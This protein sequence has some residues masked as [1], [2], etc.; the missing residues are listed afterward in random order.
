M[1]KRKR[2]SP[3][4]AGPVSDVS[5]P[6]PTMRMPIAD[7]VGSASAVAALDALSRETQAAR[8][9]GRVVIDIP[10]SNIETDFLV[11]DRLSTDPVEMQTLM[12]SIAVRSQQTPIEVVALD[13]GKFGLI[14]G[15]R[16]CAALQQLRALTGDAKYDCVQALV[17][18]PTDQADSYLSMVEENEIRVGLSYYERARIVIKATAQGAFVDEKQALKILYASASRTRRSKVKSFITVYRALNPSLRYPEAIGERLGLKLAHYIQ[19]G[20]KQSR[21][22]C[23]ALED[24]NISSSEQEKVILIQALNT[25]LEPKK[26]LRKAGSAK[27]VAGA[28]QTR[29]L[30]DGVVVR[31]YESG[32]IEVEGVPADMWDG[33]VAWLDKAMK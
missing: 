10:L 29:M 20:P 4:T 25:T 9:E 32:R 12:D 17:R 6:K 7:V 30:R 27:S 24:A 28:Y 19:K 1:A 23:T 15:W 16:R 3:M 26:T 5:T 8:A 2:L 33:L 21:V 22:L 11:R 13:Y 14:S 18:Q 31:L